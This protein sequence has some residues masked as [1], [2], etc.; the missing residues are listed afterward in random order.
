MGI[1]YLKHC[2][3]R[4]VDIAKRLGSLWEKK[5]TM[6]PRDACF[7]TQGDFQLATMVRSELS[8]A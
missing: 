7:E 3:P 2:T 8:R 1:R 6:M 5:R 4:I